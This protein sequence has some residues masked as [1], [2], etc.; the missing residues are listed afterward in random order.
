MAPER[1]QRRVDVS[2]SVM[3]EIVLPNDGNGLGNLMGGRLLHW[4]DICASISSRRHAGMVCVTAGI[5]SV[6]FESPIREGEIVILKSHVNRAFRTS[7]EVEINVWAEDTK[8]GTQRRA[9]KAYF[10]FVAISADQKPVQIPELIP[11]TDIEKS[12]YEDAGVR[13]DFRLLL[14]DRL[15]AENAPHLQT[16]LETRRHEDS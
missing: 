16:Y 8:T 7:M 9:N 3:S 2:R 6:D 12:R 1:E 4:M 14:S 5:D 10:T 15:A 13:R 11:E